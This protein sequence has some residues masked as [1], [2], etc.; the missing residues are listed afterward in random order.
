MTKTIYGIIIIVAIVVVFL[1]ISKCEPDIFVKVPGEK[2]DTVFTT[3]V[4]PGEKIYVDSAK[5]RIIYR[6]KFVYKEI[7]SY[8]FIDSSRI[9]TAYYETMAF[10]ACADTIIGKDTMG[11][12]FKFPENQFYDWYCY[13]HPNYIQDTNVTI[14]IPYEKKVWYNDPIVRLSGDVA[15]FILGI[16]AGRGTK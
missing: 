10:E 13:T 4:I 5:A 3:I 1:I 8:I 11:V 6:T 14:T 9:D 12:K 16:F 15:V 2:H 7:P